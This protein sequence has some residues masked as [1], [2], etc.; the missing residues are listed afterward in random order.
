MRSRLRC[1]GLL[2]QEGDFVLLYFNDRRWYV[3]RVRK[4]ARYSFNEG[5]IS[6]E[7]IIGRAYGESLKT[8]IGVECRI[9]KPTLCD[10]VYN[11]FKRRTQ[12]IYPKDAALIILKAG[13]GPGSRVVE[14]GTGSGFLTAILAY[15]V[16]PTGTVYTYE[17]R[18]EFLELAKAN[19]AALGVDSFVVFKNKDVREG[20]DERE[21]DAVVLDLADP[22]EVVEHAHASLRS[23]G[24]LACF[25]PTV[26]QLEKVVESAR[27]AGFVMVEA[28]ELLLRKYKVSR[29]ETRPEMRMVGHTGYLVFARKP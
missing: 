12:V 29:G 14:A 27:G 1:T 15:A 26:N 13:I 20:I 2:V 4:G 11:A 6:A 21:V 23:G 28:E 3:V 5:V 16:R 25:V 17:V 9:V 18:S 22:W 24:V 8:H 7:D 10:I 19:V